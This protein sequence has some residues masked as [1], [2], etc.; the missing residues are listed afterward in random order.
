MLARRLIALAFV[1]ASLAALPNGARAAGWWG[2]KLPDAPTQFNFGYGSLINTA[3][4]NSTASAAIP[5]I[6]VRVSAAFG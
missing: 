1:A 4:R 3:S 5:A 2:R 6:P